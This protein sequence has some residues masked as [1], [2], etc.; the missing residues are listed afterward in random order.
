MRGLAH[1]ILHARMFECPLA[2]LIIGSAALLGTEL[3]T[4]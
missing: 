2:A 3:L 4:I 1:R